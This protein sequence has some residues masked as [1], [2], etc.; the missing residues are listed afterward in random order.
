MALEQ[1]FSNPTLNHIVIN[2]LKFL[3]PQSLAKCR[4]VSKELQE[5]IDFGD[6]ALILSQ[7]WYGGY[8]R[9]TQLEELSKK[10]WAEVTRGKMYLYNEG[11]LVFTKKELNIHKQSLKLFY[12]SFSEKLNKSDLNT[13]LKFTKIFCH[14][15]QQGQDSSDIIFNMNLIQFACYYNQLDVMKVF[16]NNLMGPETI[17]CLKAKY[18]LDDYKTAL[19]YACQKGHF[20]M[21]KLLVNLHN[22]GHLDVN[23]QTF[24]RWTPLHYA[25]YKENIEII[26]VL[27][28]AEHIKLDIADIYGKNPIHYAFKNERFDILEILS[29]HYHN[30]QTKSE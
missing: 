12:K 19:H 29:N 22:L 7:I 27:L 13:V 28:D 26:K 5:T 4:L 18:F 1:I 16:S 23:A 3:D 30:A 9:I 17:R 14:Q 6:K 20:E 24:S 15:R 21:V 8:L 25:V 2:I 10:K 11:S